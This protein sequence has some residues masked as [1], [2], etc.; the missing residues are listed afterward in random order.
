MVP[1]IFTITTC[2]TK[3]SGKKVLK[4]SPLWKCIAIVMILYTCD[5]RCEFYFYFD[6]TANEDNFRKVLDV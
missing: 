2:T 4:D 1:L 6:V 3:V 5:I